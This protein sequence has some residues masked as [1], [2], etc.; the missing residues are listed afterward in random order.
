MDFKK[1]KTITTMV[2]TPISDSRVTCLKVCQSI[3]KPM[4][5]QVLVMENLNTI[6]WLIVLYTLDTVRITMMYTVQYTELL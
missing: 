3:A 6:I 2:H 5:Q 1:T 4:V